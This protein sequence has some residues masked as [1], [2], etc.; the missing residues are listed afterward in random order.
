MRRV[1]GDEPVVELDRR[2][3]DLDRPGGVVG[4]RSLTLSGSKHSM[5]WM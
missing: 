5:S 4:R 3:D 2:V 1:P